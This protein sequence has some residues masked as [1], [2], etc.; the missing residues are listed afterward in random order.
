VRAQGEGR[1]SLEVE[2]VETV[3]D[4]VVSDDVGSGGRLSVRSVRVPGS[5]ESVVVL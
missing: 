3:H 4:L 5:D 2:E 1:T